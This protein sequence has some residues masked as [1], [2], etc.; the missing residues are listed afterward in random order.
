MARTYEQEMHSLSPYSFRCYNKDLGGRREQRYSTLDRIGQ[1]DLFELLKWFIMSKTGAYHIMD[2]TKQVYQF[3][4]VSINEETR[5]LSGWFNVG[6]YG[7]KT[8]IID[9]E[10]GEVDFKKAQK[11][12]EI[13]KHYVHFYIPQGVNEAMAFLH[14]YRGNGIKTL[15]HIL[16]STYFKTVTGLNLQMNPLAYDKA[17]NAWLDAQAK[18]VKLTKFVGLADAADQLRKLGHNEQELVIKPP[19][20]G[21]LGR[22]RDY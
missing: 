16:F 21:S 12:A 5:E 14:S 15:F 9:I 2:D 7:I 13:I 19:R 20:R 3:S 8:D 17:L 6:Y 11:N 18:E 22:L 1:Y 4:D 10:T